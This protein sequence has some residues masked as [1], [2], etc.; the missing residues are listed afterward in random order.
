MNNFDSLFQDALTHHKAGRLDEAA[1]LYEAA[2][3][4]QPDHTDA[5]CNL[6]ALKSSQGMFDDAAGHYQQ[7]LMLLP[8]DTATLTNYANML[9]RKGT[10]EEAEAYYRRALE[11]DPSSI[12]TCAGLGQALLGM[13]RFNDAVGTFRQLV[14]QHDQSAEAWRMLANAQF[15]SSQNDDAAA[16][17]SRC[18][19]LDPSDSEAAYMFAN[20]ERNRGNL[21][22]AI[23]LYRLALQ[24]STHS[25]ACEIA[26]NLSNVLIDSQRT[27]EAIKVL[28]EVLKHFPDFAE[29]WNNLGSAYLNSDLFDEAIGAYR[30][31][32]VASPDMVM[33]AN[34]IGSAHLRAGRP[35]QALVSYQQ[36]IARFP[37]HPGAWTGVGNVNVSLEK[38]DEGIEAYGKA[39]EIS[40]DHID[41]IHGRAVANHRRATAF[42][43]SEHCA[44]ALEDYHRVAD[45]EP[46]HF[47]AH[48]NMGS[49]L[50]I[51][52]RHEEAIDAFRRALEINPGYV[53]AYSSLAHSLQQCCRWDN[54]DAII[55]RVIDLTRNEISTGTEI[56]TSPF[57]LLQISAPGD[58]RLAAARHLSE[59]FTRASGQADGPVF[60]YEDRTLE[61]LARDD[62]ASDDRKLRI[63]Y[64]SPDFRG[65]SVGR[66]FLELLS[67]HDRD[68]FEL[69]GYF[70]SSGSDD[71]TTQLRQ[72][73][74]VFR[75]LNGLPFLEAARQINDDR[76]DILVDLAGH[77]RGSRFEIL[78]LKPAPVQAH[79]LGYGFTTGADYVDWL[80]TDEITIPEKERPWVVENIVYLPHQ[81]LPASRPVISEKTFSRAEFGL[82]EDGFVFADFNGHY[83]IDADIFTAWMRILRK[84]PDA[85]LWLMDFNT[86][87][88]ENLKQEARTRGVDPDRLVFASRLPNEEHLAR[89]SLADLALDTYHHA[90]GVTSTDALWAGLPVLTLLTDKMV[91][92]TGASLMEAAEL[93]E[94]IATSID[95]YMQRALKYYD[96]RPAL[97][98]L[99]T[100]LREKQ[101]SAPL[102]DTPGMTRDLESAFK[103]MWQIW[104]SKSD[105]KLIRIS[106]DAL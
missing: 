60:S 27:D 103:N 43:K 83:K 100:R 58:V 64:M 1:G 99:K 81:S 6:A 46:R 8:R 105:E 7:V 53:A 65:H 15:E 69:F 78:A 79:F 44:Q 93:P 36:N 30:K 38:F 14:N 57:N 97:A 41:A 95:D 2:I 10:P 74:D 42:G 12:A 67:A 5:L 63:G 22:R 21:S 45:M 49:L 84:A 31:C 80:L 51:L 17:L 56:T 86:A 71:V 75:E 9:V 23:E 70:T 66:A 20:L 62:Q 55:D 28:R 18:L 94:L 40:P 52:S 104:L 24:N 32:L 34:N 89:L 87:G 85:V 54:L 59:M 68:R 29:G 13:G 96:D 101:K 106:D 76:I 73:F 19:E 11:S 77:T 39:L 88:T 37:D 25:T 72:D 50:Q 48:H 33:A 102:F 92:R 35:D 26:A 16:S 82:P 3:A 90:G 61:D 91:D 47:H 98:D 4:V